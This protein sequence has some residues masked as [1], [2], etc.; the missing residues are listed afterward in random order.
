MTNNDSCGHACRVQTTLDPTCNGLEEEVAATVGAYS[1][2]EP[3]SNLDPFHLGYQLLDA[4]HSSTG[5][6]WWASIPLTSLAIRAC[7]L[8]LSLRNA[9]LIRT[10]LA[11]WSESAHLAQQQA[12]KAALARQAAAASKSSVSSVDVSSRSDSSDA[13]KSRSSSTGD[14]VISASTPNGAGSSSNSSS[15]REPG[16]SL[17]HLTQQY[18]GPHAEEAAAAAARR[19]SHAHAGPSHTSTHPVTDAAQGQDPPG[20]ATGLQAQLE[21]LAEWQTRM[22]MYNELRD[23]C[24]VPQPYWILVNQVAQVG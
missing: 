19:A 18:A 12:T 3:T 21:R 9:K 17:S 7:L 8:P 15:S 4:V 6:P 5:L 1:A 22:R 14:Q 16:I 24:G 20:T 13:S 10:N 11:L 2:S 23:K